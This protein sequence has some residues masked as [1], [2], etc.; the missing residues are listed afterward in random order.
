MNRIQC[1]CTN[2]SF[3]LKTIYR[4]SKSICDYLSIDFIFLFF[5]KRPRRKKEAILLLFKIK[6]VTLRTEF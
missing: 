5:I 6:A 4:Q 3:N 1:K 2:L